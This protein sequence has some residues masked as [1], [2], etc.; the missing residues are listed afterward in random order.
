MS[1][2]IAIPDEVGLNKNAVSEKLHVHLT[3]IKVENM[4]LE[5]AIPSKKH[6]GG[7][8]R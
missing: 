7:Y 1:K 3:E 6:L 8:L 2:Q 4:V 5:F